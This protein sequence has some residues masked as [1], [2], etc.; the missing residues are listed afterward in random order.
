MP[1]VWKVMSCGIAFIPTLGGPHSKILL[2][3]WGTNF[4]FG[5]DLE[6]EI[7][8][9]QAIF[10]APSFLKPNLNVNP[11]QVNENKF[12]KFNKLYVSLAWTQQG[13][14]PYSNT[15]VYFHCMSFKLILKG[16]RGP[17][18]IPHKVI[19]TPIFV[20]KNTSL[21]CNEVIILFHPLDATQTNWFQLR[22]INVI[23]ADRCTYNPQLY[24]VQYLPLG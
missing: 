7:K 20:H 22:T 19:G 21:L 18:W 11:P 24:H 14:F 2:L 5:S 6:F 23:V 8:G 10:W 15:W 13:Q 9:H 16:L 1:K 3:V 17:L 12:N 4:K